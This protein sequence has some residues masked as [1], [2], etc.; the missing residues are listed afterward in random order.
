MTRETEDALLLGALAL[1]AYVAFRWLR[2][3]IGERVGPLTHAIAQGWVWATAGAPASV[4]AA[5]V[6]PDGTAV[7][8][9]EIPQTWHD[10]TGAVRF[11]FGGK[12]YV[13][14]PNPQGGPAYDTEG[15]YHAELA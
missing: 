1:G 3:M 13:I 15:N 8:F 5:V 6:L 12:S 4:N 14:L 9:D 2:G 7:P 11:D 10:Q